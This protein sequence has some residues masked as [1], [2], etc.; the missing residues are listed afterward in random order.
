MSSINRCAHCDNY[1]HRDMP[2]GP[3]EMRGPVW[4]G[5]PTDKPTQHESAERFVC[6]RNECAKSFVVGRNDGQFVLC[7]HCGRWAKNKERV[8]TESVSGP[9]GSLPFNPST[10]RRKDGKVRFD[11]LVQDMPRALEALA[12]VMT[13][14][15]E[16]KGYVEHDWLNVPDAIKEYHGALHRHDNKEMKGITH[17]HESKFHHAAH[18]AWNAMARVELIL[19]EEEAKR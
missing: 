19:R 1:H 2:C 16:E 9:I 13:W 15:I 4:N 18:V 10:D 17:D 6:P 8:V 14:A 5:R 3:M 7:P 11:L 12:K